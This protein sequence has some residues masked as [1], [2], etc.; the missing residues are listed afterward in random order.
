[1]FCLFYDSGFFKCAG[2]IEELFEIG[3]DSQDLRFIV[4]GESYRSSVKYFLGDYNSCIKANE[5]CRNTYDFERDFGSYDDIGLDSKSISLLWSSYA[6]WV[7]G[8]FN[9][10]LDLAN[11]NI[12]H[13]KISKHP[14]HIMLNNT[15]GGDILSF[16]GHSERHLE[17]INEARK[18]SREL[19]IPFVEHC[20]CAIHTG[21]AQIFQKQYVEAEKNLRQGF[22]LWSISGGKIHATQGYTQIAEALI[23]QE[24]YEEALVDW[25]EAYQL[26]QTTG[27]LNWECE[28]Y[29][30]RGE[31][32]RL[33]PEIDHAKA[34]TEIRRA[35]DLAESKGARSF[36]LRAA[37]SMARLW[38]EDDRRIKARDLLLPNYEWFTDGIDTPDM[39]DARALLDELS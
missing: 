35:M 8:N 1:M 11:E 31:L 12:E 6:H 38:Q 14:L 7:V 28:I 30:V 27:E 3:N 9:V 20:P 32:W 24:R 25:T 5:N 13:A 34:E 23:G 26:M 36:Q 16:L 19:E 15:V 29:R 39:Q 10:A 2:Y 18:M 4:F 33:G 22:E 21:I 17:L 37:M